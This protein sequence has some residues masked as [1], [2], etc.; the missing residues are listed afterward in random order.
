M[1][2][3]SCTSMCPKLEI[4]ARTKQRRVH[5]LERSLD[6]NEVDI[7]RCVKEYVRSAAGSEKCDQPSLLRTSETL[8]Q[9]VDYLLGPL[10]YSSKQSILCITNFI[11]DRL[12]AIRQDLIVQ[13]FD[14]KCGIPILE[15]II[16]YHLL[17]GWLNR[18]LPRSSFDSTLNRTLL[19]SYIADLLEYYNMAEINNEETFLKNYPEFI[20]FYILMHLDDSHVINNA[21][22]KC[23]HLSSDYI[24]LDTKLLTNAL[25]CCRLYH[26][27][28]YYRLLKIALTEL[29]L[30]QR[31]ALLH[32]FSRLRTS[33][34]SIIIAGYSSKIMKLP[35]KTLSD[36]FRHCSFSDSIVLL[37]ACGI[38]IDKD[39][40]TFN[41]S[42]NIDLTDIQY[43]EILIKSDYNEVID[44]SQV[45]SL[46]NL[47]LK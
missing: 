15:R 18:R 44:N 3:G 9:T 21:Y 46:W 42:N 37:E 41:K 38:P 11:T 36:W 30:L 35:I 5:P 29:S 8:L 24:S 22:L 17:V 13:Q 39:L 34:L 25:H 1:T 33:Y 14:F 7:T 2:T 47:L 23:L 19:K 43:E 27:N 26:N 40:V 28:N 4:E 10:I 31:L 16:K 12:R 45:L 20:S 32:N 6:T